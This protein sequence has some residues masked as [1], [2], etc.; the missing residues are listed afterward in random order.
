MKAR[1]ASPLLRFITTIGLASLALPAC[2]SNAEA[3]CDLKCE[4]EGCSPSTLDDCYFNGTKDERE[5][6]GKGCL[7]FYDDLK[8]CEYDTAFCKSGNDFDTACKTEK[9]RYDNCK[10]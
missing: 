7:D 6:D 9:E 3:V 5:A 10:K 1:L 4:C 2:R 8:A